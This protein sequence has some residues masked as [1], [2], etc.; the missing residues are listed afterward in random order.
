MIIELSVMHNL[1][2]MYMSLELM[3]KYLLCYKIIV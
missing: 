2:S 1:E 3:I